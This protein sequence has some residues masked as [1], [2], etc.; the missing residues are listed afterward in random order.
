MPITT[1]L[2]KLGILRIFSDFFTFSFT[3]TAI[4]VIGTVDCDW[5]GLINISL[6]NGS[7][8]N[9]DRRACIGDICD[10]PWF[11]GTNLENKEHTLNITLTGPPIAQ[12]PSKHIIADFRYIL[13]TVPDTSS[14]S[15]SSSSP[16]GT[17][18]SAPGTGSHKSVNGSL[19]GGVVAGV[20]ILLLIGIIV[21]LLLARK[22]SR[23]RQPHP[24]DLGAEQHPLAPT[25]LTAPQ[26]MVWTPWTPDGAVT[27]PA[28]ETTK[29]F[30]WTTSTAALIPP[31]ALAAGHTAA[32]SSSSGRES[33]SERTDSSG[34]NQQQS[35]GNILP[36]STDPDLVQR[37]SATVAAMLREGSSPPPAYEPPPPGQRARPRK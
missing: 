19:I 1:L 17:S 2:Y 28:S 3:G 30:S 29:S 7:P 6:D 9:F 27:T 8:A 35:L 18:T 16:A 31:G 12:A 32:P 24:I 4:Y 21:F 37:I 14:S 22:R 34:T 13:Y 33:N 26:D 15:P 10:Y 23:Q 36:S 20:V 25:G 5:S 11:T